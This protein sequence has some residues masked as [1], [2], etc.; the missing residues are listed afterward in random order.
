MLIK[1]YNSNCCILY[2]LYYFQRKIPCSII[3]ISLIFRIIFYLAKKIDSSLTY[4]IFF[5]FVILQKF[6]LF[7]YFVTERRTSV[8]FHVK[9]PFLFFFI[10]FAMVIACRPIPNDK[11]YTV[12]AIDLSIQRNC[13]YFSLSE[14]GFSAA[15]SL[16][17]IVQR[18]RELILFRC[19]LTWHLAARWTAIAVLIGKREHP[20]A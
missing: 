11:K 20:R 4:S 9:F 1:Y 18:P 2:N 17:H 10:V 3:T 8:W 12:H 5:L 19:Q 13:V 6:H 16:E 15:C 7:E 14:G